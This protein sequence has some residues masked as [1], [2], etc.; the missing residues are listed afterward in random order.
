MYGTT[1]VMTFRVESDITGSVFTLWAS[2]AI[3]FVHV[4]L[5]TS[6]P[7]E[8]LALSRSKR[9]VSKQQIVVNGQCSMLTMTQ[10]AKM[11]A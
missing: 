4:D 9:C 10:P 6:L 5:T 3:T 1:G 7:L 8:L 2:R 11:V